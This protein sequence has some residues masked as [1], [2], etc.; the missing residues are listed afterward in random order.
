[1][2]QVELVFYHKS[3]LTSKI[4]KSDFFISYVETKQL[5]ATTN[6]LNTPKAQEYHNVPIFLISN[7]DCTNITSHFPNELH[8]RLCLCLL[9][10]CLSF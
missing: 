8:L 6:N 7:L 4:V 9:L 2:K 1:M 5:I 3:L 10:V